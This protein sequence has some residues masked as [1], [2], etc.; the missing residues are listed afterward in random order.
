VAR[1]ALRNVLNQG[2]VTWKEETGYVDG[3]SVPNL[4]VLYCVPLRV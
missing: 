4:A 3:F 1:V 2:T